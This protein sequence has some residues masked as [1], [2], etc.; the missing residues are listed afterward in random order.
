METLKSIGS[1]LKNNLIGT[2]A[3]AAAGYYAAKKS[4]KVENKWIL[5]GLTVI[6]A[7]AGAMIEYKIKA[8]TVKP[9]LAAAK[10]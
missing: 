1:S 6:S 5:G 10:K 8:K 4:G 2:L 7:I 9:A 3:G